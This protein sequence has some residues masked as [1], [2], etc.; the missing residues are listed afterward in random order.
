MES[1]ARNGASVTQ[2]A[3]A[4]LAYVVA[5]IANTVV[6][7]VKLNGHERARVHASFC[8]FGRE[9]IATPSPECL[10][11]TVHVPDAPDKAELKWRALGDETDWVA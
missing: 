5:F 11:L 7:F 9:G 4:L 1:R 6:V 3:S 2:A 10:H 8:T